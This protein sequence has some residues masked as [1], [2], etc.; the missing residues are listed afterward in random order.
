LS[1]K[2]VLKVP[3]AGL[4]LECSVKAMA[5]LPSQAFAVTLNDKLLEDMIACVQNGQEIQLSLG[6][7]PVSFAPFYCGTR[8]CFCASKLYSRARRLLCCTTMAECWDNRVQVSYR[9]A[10]LLFNLHCTRSSH[11]S[12]LPTSML[13]SS[14]LLFLQASILTT[15]SDIS[16]WRPGIS[17]P[18]FFKPLRIRPLLLKFDE[19]QDS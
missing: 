2:M 15:S 9:D 10:S 6:D 16:T 17:D 3:D 5:A 8:C 1:V 13:S 12:Y 18:R 4:A 14:L 7:A 19:P 11:S